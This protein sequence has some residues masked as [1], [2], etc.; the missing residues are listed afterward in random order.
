MKVKDIAY[1]T[2]LN[3]DFIITDTYGH[4]L[5]KGNSYDIYN[6]YPK[7]L[8]KDVESVDVEG[9]TI[10]LMLDFKVEA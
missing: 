9:G 6:K 7:Y 4:E 8:F 10:K 5:A 1:I 2:K 3:V